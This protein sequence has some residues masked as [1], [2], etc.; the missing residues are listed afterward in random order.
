MESLDKASAIPLYFQLKRWL[1]DRIAEGR[2]LPGQQISSGTVQA[3]L[4]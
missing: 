1:V 4:A 2:L 3:V